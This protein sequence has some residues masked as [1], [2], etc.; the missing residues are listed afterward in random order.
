MK[1][2]SKLFISFLIFIGGAIV[3]LFFSTALDSLLSHRLTR[4][5][6]LPIEY[7]IESLVTSRQHFL[8]FLCIQGFFLLSAVLYY[9][10][11]MHSY[12]SE[13]DQITPDIETPRAVGQYQHGSARW[14]SD[15]EK[16]STFSS[17]VINPNDKYIKSLIDSGYDDIEFITR[18]DES[19]DTDKEPN[20]NEVGE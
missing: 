10:T 19:N 13:L 12:K 14:M 20:S 11:D 5:T 7:C 2:K 1:T 16:D 17:Y 8:L 15:S 4:L 18:K 6:I 3:N 9:T